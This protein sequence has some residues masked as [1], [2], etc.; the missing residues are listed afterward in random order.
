MSKLKLGQ[1]NQ[2]HQKGEFLFFVDRSVAVIWILNKLVSDY[3]RGRLL[4]P[5][6]E[7]L[8]CVIIPGSRCS[9]YWFGRAGET[10]PARPFCLQRSDVTGVQREAYAL[11]TGS[12][13]GEQVI[14]Y[15]CES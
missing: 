15:Q 9:G 7:L 14:A 2:K 10:F 3:E 6:R 4:G 11:Y 1:L 5:N 8:S 13:T 12:C